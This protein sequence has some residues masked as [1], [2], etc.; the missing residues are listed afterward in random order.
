ML[1]LGVAC[2]SGK[3]A[4]AGW[5]GLVETLCFGN[6]SVDGGVENFVDAGHFFTAALHVESAH[7]LGD[8]LTLVGGDGG[9]SLCL[10][11]VDAGALVAQ[12]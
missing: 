12:V 10:E 9:Q 6:D 5:W 8:G 4:T 1:L 7:L 2:R 3:A 11:E